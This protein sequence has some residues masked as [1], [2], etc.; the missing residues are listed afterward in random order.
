MMAGSFMSD[1]WAYPTWPA[2]ALPLAWGLSRAWKSRRPAYRSG[3]R[4]AAQAL[5][6]ALLCAEIGGVYWNVATRNTDEKLY[7]SAL[8]HTSSPVMKYNLGL[9]LLRQGR[10]AEALSYLEQVQGADPTDANVARAV[11][12]A[13]QG[14]RQGEQHP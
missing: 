3:R 12:I 5:W 4:T 1:H 11:S 7:R 10:P 2:L 13:R 9:V 6:V 8:H 14:V